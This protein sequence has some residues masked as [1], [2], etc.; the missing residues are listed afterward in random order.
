M[1]PGFPYTPG[2]PAGMPKQLKTPPC[3]SYCTLPSG[4]QSTYNTR[5][6]S[7]NPPLT[8]LSGYEGFDGV[9]DTAESLFWKVAKSAAAFVVAYKVVQ[10]MDKPAKTAKVAGWAAAGAAFLFL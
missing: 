1:M 5:T 4:D 9:G 3:I 7:W 10:S 2:L 6:G 8:A